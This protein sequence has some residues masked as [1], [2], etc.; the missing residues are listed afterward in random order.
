[1][2]AEYIDSGPAH[3]KRFLLSWFGLQAH[4]VAGA[5]GV[6]AGAEVAG[7]RVTDRHGGAQTAVGGPAD[8]MSPCTQSVGGALRD[9]IFKVQPSG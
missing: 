8:I 6:G 9:A 7:L 1:M 4:G 5:A 2:R 3:S